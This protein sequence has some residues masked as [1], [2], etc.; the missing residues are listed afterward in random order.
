MNEEERKE[1]ADAIK[2][3]VSETIAASGLTEAVKKLTPGDNGN[4]ASE[5]KFKSFGEFL[6][7]IK[8]NPGDA[9]L[10][11]LS[12]GSDPGGGFTVPEEFL[13]TMFQ[14]AVERSVIRPYATKIPM[15]TDT[16]NIPL[17]NDTTHTEAGGLFGGVI[18]HWTEEAGS[19]THTDP[20]FRRVKLIAKKLTGLT[21]ASDELLADSAIALEALL[22]KLFGDA[23]AWYED[24]AFIDGSGVGE[25]LGWMNSGALIQVTRN[26]LASVVQADLAGMLGRLYPASHYGPNTVWIANPSVLP[27]LVAVA[28]TSVTWIALDQGMTKRV[29]TSIFGMP[30]LFSEKMQA[31]GTVGDI[32][33][34]DLSYYLIGDRS[35]VKVNRSIEYRFDTDETTWRF[36]KRVDGQP[37]TDEVFTPKHGATLSPFIV[38]S[39]ATS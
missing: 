20:V 36:V 17:L 27:Q 12:E 38:L 11:Q 28:T 14:R 21:Y 4:G 24:E 23:I 18:A 31:L 2:A 32:A 19:K 30:L 16:L 25:P 26:T 3:E 8:N 37:W 39:T 33:L 22:I 5:G 7:A 29:P 6:C 1:L 34:C 15:G 10:K 35:G 9:R 13:V